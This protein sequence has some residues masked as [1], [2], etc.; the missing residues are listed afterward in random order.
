[1]EA[2]LPWYLDC[3]KR[4]MEGRNLPSA[5]QREPH[6]TRG[7]EETFT[8]DLI[9]EQDLEL[10]SEITPYLEVTLAFL[11]NDCPLSRLCHLIL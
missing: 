10:L 1:M 5:A 9:A 8:E 11:R 2:N 4:V 7:N 3:N 6:F